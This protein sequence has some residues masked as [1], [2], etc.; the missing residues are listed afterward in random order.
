MTFKIGFTDYLC[1]I[2]GS[3][4]I[5]FYSRILDDFIVTVTFNLRALPNNMQVKKQERVLVCHTTQ[6]GAGRLCL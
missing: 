2:L 5:A 1:Y 4:E 6:P 3:H